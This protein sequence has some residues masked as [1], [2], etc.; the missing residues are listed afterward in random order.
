[1]AKAK[2]N[3]EVQPIPTAAIALPTLD[4]RAPGDATN[5]DDLIHSIKEIGLLQPI[6]VKQLAEGYEVIAGA[7]RLR[8]FISLRKP[9]IPAI[10]LPLDGMAAELAK[11]HEN[12]VRRDVSPVEE[13]EFLAGLQ[14]A[15]KLTGKA[16]AKKIDRTESYVSERLALLNSPQ[17]LRDAISAGQ[18]SFSAARELCRIKSPQVRESY[19]DAAI[20]SGI[21]DA[22]AKQWRLDANTANKAGEAAPE[23]DPDRPHEKPIAIK[24][25]CALTGKHLSIERTM[26]VRVAIDAWNDLIAAAKE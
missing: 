26:I 2:E 21:N 18:L 4:M 20:R 9:T 10:V 15:Y 19:I 8:A 17:E 23:P 12:Q 11:M 25:Q 7:R 24:V 13:A 3:P 5:V 16:L 6:I 1:M 22:T 14:K